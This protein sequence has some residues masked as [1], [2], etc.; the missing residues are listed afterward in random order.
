LK[1]NL[2]YGREK[3]LFIIE[4]VTELNEVELLGVNGG[5]CTSSYNP[6]NAPPTSPTNTSPG[7]C[8]PGGCSPG[9][10]TPGTCPGPATVP[11]KCNAL[12]GPGPDG[13][14]FDDMKF[15]DW[16]P[17]NYKQGGVADLYARK[18]GLGFSDIDFSSPEEGRQRTA[19]LYLYLG[20]QGL[21][22]NILKLNLQS[23]TSRQIASGGLTITTTRQQNSFSYQLTD[24][25]L[26]RN[27]LIN[28]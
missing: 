20:V 5:T 21:T 16:E 11:G 10:C 2:W 17:K 22:T 15:Y 7:S 24:V 3:M 1:Y 26:Q 25:L 6:N 8:S 14:P 12:D 27:L 13:T 4:G 19:G 18:F 9:A 28:H 23:G